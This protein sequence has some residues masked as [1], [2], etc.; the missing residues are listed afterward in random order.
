LVSLIDFNIILNSSLDNKNKEEPENVN[1]CM[2]FLTI[3]T[4]NLR[5]S[6]I[7][8]KLNASL[9]ALKLNVYKF[10]IIVIPAVQLLINGGYRTLFQIKQTL[11]PERDEDNPIMPLVVVADSGRMAKWIATECKL[12]DNSGGAGHKLTL[13]P[14]IPERLKLKEEIRLEYPT[15]VDEITRILRR[16]VKERRN[17][18]S[19]L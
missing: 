6:H 3:F 19:K 12:S 15:K 17:F 9:F 1:K 14:T 7:L 5:K 8:R 11:F 13:N 4:I 2:Y 10:S 18:V 16:I